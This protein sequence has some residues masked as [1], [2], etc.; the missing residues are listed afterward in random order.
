MYLRLLI[1]LFFLSFSKYAFPQGGSVRIAVYG[2]GNVDFVFNS[3]SDY[4]AGITLTNYTLIGIDVIDLAAPPD[5]ESWTLSISADDPGIDGLDGTGPANKFP[6]NAIQVRT[7]LSGGCVSCNFFGSPWVNLPAAPTIFV[8]GNAAG[9]ADD[10]PPNLGTATDQ[11][12][13]SYR[14]GVSTSLL[15]LSLPADYYSDD[16]FIDL[17]MTSP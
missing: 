17:L 14:C 6:L 3:M 5:W 13:I 8:D 9:G 2:G 12:N 10:I 11:I 16:I 4:T 15:G 7:T 1:F